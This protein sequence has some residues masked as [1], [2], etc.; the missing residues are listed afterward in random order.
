M[1]NLLTLTRAEGRVAEQSRFEWGLADYAHKIIKF[2]YSGFSKDARKTSLAQKSE[3]R[4]IQKNEQTSVNR[5]RKLVQL[6]TADHVT[7]KLLAL[8]VLQFSC[9]HKEFR[10]LL[11]H[12]THH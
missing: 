2:C 1:Y 3:Q 4:Y 5:Y 9:L 11:A 7:P 8:V 6:R 12:L 10:S